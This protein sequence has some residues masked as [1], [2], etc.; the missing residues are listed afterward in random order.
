MQHRIN[1]L[2]LKQKIA[3]CIA[4]YA[5]GILLAWVIDWY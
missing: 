4:V 5:S 2:P 3:L 1:T